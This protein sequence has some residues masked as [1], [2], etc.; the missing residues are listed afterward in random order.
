MCSA[1]RCNQV[2][3][4]R[5]HR[6]TLLAEELCQQ[7]RLHLCQHMVASNHWLCERLRPSFWM[8]RIYC[9]TSCLFCTPDGMLSL[10]GARS[11]P[12]QQISIR[13]ST[14]QAVLTRLIE[15]LTLKCVTM[16]RLPCYI[17]VRACLVNCCNH[18]LRMYACLVVLQLKYFY[19]PPFLKLIMCSHTGVKLRLPVLGAGLLQE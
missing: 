9:S 1:S 6:D 7:R 19:G 8:L 4:A 12:D 15:V 2:L 16:P 14:C 13:F 3:Q 17:F 10:L 18:M 5:A 11:H